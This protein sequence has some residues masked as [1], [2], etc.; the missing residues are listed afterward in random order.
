MT[1]NELLD[2]MKQQFED[3]CGGDLEYLSGTCLE[4][5]ARAIRSGY[6][7]HAQRRLRDEYSM[8]QNGNEYSQFCEEAGWDYELFR[9]KLEELE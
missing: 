2:F 8:G 1:D 3:V 9:M 5:F 4:R 6:Q 7:S